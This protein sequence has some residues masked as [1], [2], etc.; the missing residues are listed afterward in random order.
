MGKTLKCYTLQEKVQMIEACKTKSQVQ[1]SQ[2][3]NIARGTLC[4]YLKDKVNLLKQYEKSTPKSANRKRHRESKEADI[5]E[6]LFI[7]SASPSPTWRRR[8]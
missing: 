3:F 1:V 2:E 7:S 5:E 6:A 8:C 4:G